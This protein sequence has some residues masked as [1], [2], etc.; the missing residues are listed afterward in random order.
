MSSFD[1]KQSNRA[2]V[3]GERNAVRLL[4][5]EIVEDP[6]QSHIVSEA[7][8]SKAINGFIGA[9]PETHL[10]VLAKN[11]H[12]RWNA[13]HRMLGYSK[14]DMNTP[15]INKL[16]NKEAKQLEHFWKHA[17]LVEFDE[18]PFVDVAVARAKDP[19]DKTINVEDYKCDF[20]GKSNKCSFQF[21]DYDFVKSIWTDVDSAGMKIV[22]KTIS[23]DNGQEKTVNG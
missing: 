1:Q 8:F 11:E 2:F 6:G 17:C 5:Y 9:G 4:G 10:S 3:F 21:Y 18:L 12:L 15:D 23:E 20:Y 13:Y 22:D 14:W 16:E 7:E 19:T